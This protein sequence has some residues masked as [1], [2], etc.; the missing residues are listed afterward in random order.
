MSLLASVLLTIAALAGQKQNAFD[1][2]A[3]RTEWNNRYDYIVIGGGSAGS[4]VATRLS[5]NPKVNVLLIEAGKQPIV[6]WHT[7]SEE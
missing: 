7:P 2:L 6:E 4:V 3:Q 1:E 5:E